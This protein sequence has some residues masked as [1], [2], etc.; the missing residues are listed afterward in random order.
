MT[1]GSN[2]PAGM[3]AVIPLTLA[4]L[5]SDQALAR[6]FPEYSRTT[7]KSWILAGL[8]QVDGQCVE[9]RHVVSGGE[10]VELAPPPPS[11][12]RER[13]EAIPLE[14]IHEDPEIWVVNK[15]AGLVVHPG[16][17]NREGTLLNALLHLDPGLAALP[18]AGIVHRLDKD[19]S[20]L[21]VIAR[22]PRAHQSLVA[23]LKV[24]RITRE[25]QGIVSGAMV[26]GAS[27]EA[28]IGRHPTHRTHMAVVE[29][30]GKAAVTHYRVIRRFRLHTQVRLMLETGRTHQ[31]RVHMAH[32]RYPLV[33]DPVYGGRVRLPPR[34][35][36]ALGRALRE[37]PRQALHAARLALEH[38]ATGVSLSFAAPL[39]ADMAALIGLLTE[40]AE[41]AGPVDARPPR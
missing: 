37:F 22:S 11:P 3:R 30:G 36:P 1:A 32:V 39:P 13:P 10:A 26:A 28:A 7:L 34:A 21:L 35:L 41:R 27:V 24:R 17:G 5:R 38:P 15:A 16:A 2:E 20:G 19:T 6:V 8:V 18:R 40:D 31:I 25:Y 9:P 4:G 14:V 33:G 29:R 12:M 23:Q